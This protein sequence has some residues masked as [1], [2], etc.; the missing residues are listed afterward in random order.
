MIVHAVKD[1]NITTYLS[2]H[3]NELE[4]FVGANWMICFQQAAQ[5]QEAVDHR[6]R[7]IDT[8]QLAH[9]DQLM[10]LST[11]SEAVARQCYGEKEEREK[12]Y[13]QLLSEMNERNKVEEKILVQIVVWNRAMWMYWLNNSLEIK[14]NELVSR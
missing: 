5:L 10:K 13:A 1:C 8:I 4:Y 11:T 14:W 6:D 2:L 9:E 12:H 3:W 7:I